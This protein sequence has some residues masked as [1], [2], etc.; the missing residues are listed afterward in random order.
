MNT[1]NELIGLFLDSPLQA[2]ALS[3]AFFFFLYFFF[4][5]MAFLVSHFHG[6]GF[7]I[8]QVPYSK[9]QI[10]K[11]IKYSML[12]ILVF[13]LQSIFIQQ[14]IANGLA[15]IETSFTLLTYFVEVLLLFFWNE[16]HFYCTHWLLHR[17]WWFINIHYLHHQSFQPTP[18]SVYSFSW[19]EAFL[20]GSVIFLPLLLHRFQIISMVSLPIMS[21]MMNVIGHWDYD[22][23]PDRKVD[24]WLRASFRHSL[25]HSKVSGNFGFQLSF[26]DKLFKTNIYP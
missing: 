20:L 10:L 17:K 19:V 23:F 4:S 2:F 11:E 8:N 26:F 22:F 6:V 9:S 21:I 13:S 25:H 1:T 18:F 3:F 5:G 14:A 15:G 16:L 12:S 7:K 24:H